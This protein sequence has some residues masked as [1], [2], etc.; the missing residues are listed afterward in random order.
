MR[1]TPTVYSNGISEIVLTHYYRVNFDSL[2]YILTNIGQKKNMEKKSAKSLTMLTF[3]NSLL[4]QK[5][6]E[7]NIRS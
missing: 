4:S 6:S 7:N 3:M 1:L 2:S 5:Y